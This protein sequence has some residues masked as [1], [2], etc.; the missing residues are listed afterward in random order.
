[1]QGVIDILDAGFHSL[2]NLYEITGNIDILRKSDSRI[3]DP[4][5]SVQVKAT[6]KGERN[7]I[8]HQQYQ[9]VHRVLSILPLLHV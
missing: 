4:L 6:R 1:M 7:D 2:R 8:Q 5:R 9:K 3:L